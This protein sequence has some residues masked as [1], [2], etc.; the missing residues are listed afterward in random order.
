MYIVTGISSMLTKVNGTIITFTK[1]VNNGILIRKC[2][3]QAIKGF[4]QYTPFAVNKKYSRIGDV[5]R[6]RMVTFIK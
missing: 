2:C 1:Y 4:V 3:S 6:I 5:K